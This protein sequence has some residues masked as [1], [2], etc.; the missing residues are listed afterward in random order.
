MHPTTVSPVERNRPVIGLIPTAALLALVALAFTMMAIRSESQDRE[1]AAQARSTATALYA[2]CLTSRGNALALHNTLEVLAN[3]L[4]TRRDMTP[5]EIR[6]RAQ[7]YRGA[8]PQ[9]PD[10]GD[11]P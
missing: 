1:I 10:C 7:S 6:T 2:Q 4:A 8:K 3:S 9:I 11:R 5:A